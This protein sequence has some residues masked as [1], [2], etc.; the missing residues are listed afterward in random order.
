[1]SLLSISSCETT[2]DISNIVILGDEIWREH[3]T[4]IIGEN[5]VTY[6]LDKFQSN[7]AIKSQINEGYLYFLLK[8]GN[9]NIG[10]FS[11]QRRDK[12]LFLSKVYIQKKHRGKGYFQK[13]MNHVTTLA[14]REFCTSISLT[15]NKYNTNSINIYLNKGFKIM[16]SAVFAIGNGYV[17]DDYVMELK[18]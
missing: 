10:Y 2:Q 18:F 8:E 12:T 14:H 15:V 17:M 9:I 5:Q 6:M 1:M 16:E 13:T 3:Y 11:V 7:E 4:P